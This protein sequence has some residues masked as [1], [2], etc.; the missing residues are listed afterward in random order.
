MIC[1]ACRT[2]FKKTESLRTHW[3]ETGC[4][5]GRPVWERFAEARKRGSSGRRILHEAFPNLYPSEPMS[6]EA[7]EKLRAIAEQ[8]KAEGVKMP[9]KRK[10]KI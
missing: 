7:K 2:S 10:I 8:R 9:K 5:S 1:G 6:E 3:E 4:M